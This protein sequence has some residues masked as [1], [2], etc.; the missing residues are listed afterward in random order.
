MKYFSSDH[1]KP[2]TDTVAG[3]TIDPLAQLLK[4]DN[5]HV[6]F[7]TNDTVVRA[8][9]GLSYSLNKGETVAILGESG[10]GKSVAAQA[11]R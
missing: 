5:L 2:E 11:E 7:Q 4:V 3:K 8:V 1:K 10:S 6:E 9:N